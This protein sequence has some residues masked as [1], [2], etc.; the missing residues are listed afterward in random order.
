MQPKTKMINRISDLPRTAKTFEKRE[1][2]PLACPGGKRAR[3]WRVEL[4]L[5]GERKSAG[6]TRSLS[7]SHNAYTTGPTRRPGLGLGVSPASCALP[8]LYL[9]SYRTKADSDELG[10]IGEPGRE[11]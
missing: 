2:P 7:H 11:G 1:H 10:Q 9:A 6:D 3:A 4:S 8:I 5:H